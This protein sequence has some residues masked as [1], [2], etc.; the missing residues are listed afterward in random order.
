MEKLTL[1][2]V[3][4]F[5]NMSFAQNTIEKQ[6]GDFNELKVYDLIEVTLIKSTENKIII[7]GKH[8]DEVDYVNKGGK[9]K[10]RMKLDNV[11][12]GDDTKIEVYYTNLDI[13]DGNE[14][15]VITSNET[16]KQDFIELRGQEGAELAIHLEVNKLEVKSISGAVIKTYGTANTQDISVNTGGNYLG[17]A[18]ETQTTTI[19]IKAGGI[20][21]VNA[22]KTVDA[23]AQ[24]G[25]TINVYGNPETVLKHTV[26]GG[27]INE[28]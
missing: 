10:L 5:A 12:N 4:V 18:L 8:T 22:T 1:I 13:I 20:A 3:L 7:N 25:G 16:I 19:I 2:L 23:T 24:A 26:L 28:K 11:F 9:L 15:A 27:K 14:G 17:E 21:D 6:I